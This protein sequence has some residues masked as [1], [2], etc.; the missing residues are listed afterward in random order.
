MTLQMVSHIATQV[1]D[2]YLLKWL[3]ASGLAWLEHNQEHVN[4]MNVFPVPDGDTGTNMRL[5]LQKAYEAIAHVDDHN[6]AGI[7]ARFSRGALLGARGNS[8]V[9]LSQLIRG[10]ANA[11]DGHEVIDTALFA[12]AALQ[13]VDQAYTAVLEPVE[14]TILTVAREAAEALNKYAGRSDDLCRALETTIASARRALRRTPELLPVL[15]TAGVMDSGG[16]GLLYILEGMSRTI[17]GLPVVMGE[18]ELAGTPSTWEDNL[19][20]EDEEG[21]GYDVQFLMYGASMDVDRIRVELNAMGWSTLV[22][23]DAQLI[24]VHIHVHNPGEPISYAIANCDAIDDVVVENMQRQYEARLAAQNG[25]AEAPPM[26]VQKVDGVAAIAVASGDG[27][28][29]VFYDAE[30]AH[31]IHGGQT[32]N[33]S[34][35]DFLRAIEAIDNEAIV[36]LPNNKNIIMAAEQAARQS[37]RRVRVIPTTTVPQ[38]ISAML[39]YLD[40]HADAHIDDLADAMREAAGMIDTGEITTATRD[41]QIGDV[42]VKRGQYIGLVNGKL[43]VATDDQTEAVLALL[44]AANIDSHELVT[45]Y[46]G[47]DVEPAQAQALV[48]Q[49]QA[50]HP[51]QR[52]EHIEGGQP[53]YPYLLS[54]E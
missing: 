20:P 10:F 38:G 18:P 54:L 8:G 26:M 25:R 29:R 42:Q 19:H 15:K 17:N 49:L 1:C 13:A 22:V 23:G 11:V 4:Q 7:A 44:Q 12:E 5:T 9:I 14:G 46:S 37:D 28:A 2:G 31:V 30:A 39:A 48:D 3:L 53:L 6:A 24:K 34:T 36:L 41:A 33:P 51:G 27:L 21:Y 47:A 32:M 50:R 52:F 45:L 16:Q 43:F 35:D 40:L